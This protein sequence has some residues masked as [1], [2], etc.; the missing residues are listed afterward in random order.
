M[1]GGVYVRGQ[2][3]RTSSLLLPCGAGESNSVCQACWQALLPAEPPSDSLDRAFH[4]TWGLPSWLHLLARELPRIHLSVPQHFRHLSPSPTFCMSVGNL[5][6]SFHACKAGVD[7]DPPRH[8]L[9]P[10]EKRLQSIAHG[11]VLSELA[12]GLASN[13]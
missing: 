12:E 7:R 4:Q 11:K 3:V 8:L 10:C 5:S 6:S 13:L 9:G 2:F 1:W